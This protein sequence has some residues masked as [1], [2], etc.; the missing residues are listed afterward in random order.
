MYGI[1]FFNIY[2]YFPIIIMDDIDIANVADN[3]TPYMLV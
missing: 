2:L 1:I 3:N